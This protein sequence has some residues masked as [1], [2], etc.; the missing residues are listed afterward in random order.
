MAP[1]VM[2]GKSH[3]ID[4][5]YYCMGIMSYEFMKGVRPYLCRSNLELKKKIMENQIVINKLELPDGWGIESADFI[6]R[7]MMMIYIIQDY[8]LFQLMNLIVP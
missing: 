6:N 7:F 5:D 4:S 2:C 8:L 3:S 1:E